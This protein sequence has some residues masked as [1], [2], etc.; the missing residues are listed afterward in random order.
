M[1]D[2]FYTMASIA[3]MCVILLSL[4]GVSVKVNDQVYHIQVTRLQK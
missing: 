1:K 4:S 3:L 2:V